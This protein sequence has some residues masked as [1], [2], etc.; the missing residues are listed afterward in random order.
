MQ[1]TTGFFDMI[2]CFFWIVSYSIILIG[3]IKYRYPLISIFTWAVIAPYEFAVLISF[4][5]NR[6]T[7]WNYVLISYTY[8]VIIEI[9]IIL[10][11]V[12]IGYI[13]KKRYIPYFFL[14][15][16]V[17]MIMCY[18]VIVKKQMF[19]FAY[20]NT[21]VGEI[22]WFRHIRKKDY[23]VKPLALWVFIAKYL[24]DAFAISVYF[25]AG[26][27][28]TDVMSVALPLLDFAFVITYFQ[29]KLNMKR[30]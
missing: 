26:T 1:G 22:I 25:G 2:Q 24:A 18:M 7:E 17:T 10:S 14:V 16:A 5:I 21:L 30:F 19:F 23:P 29:K 11:I 27:L 12:K 6:Q 28:L 9:L 20:F 4:I 15:S 8:W 13:S 3:T